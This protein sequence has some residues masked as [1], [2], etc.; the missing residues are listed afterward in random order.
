M[1]LTSRKFILAE[2]GLARLVWMPKDLKEAM[3][4]QLSARAQ[5]MGLNG[6][7]DKIADE[8]IAIDS[9]TLMA[10]LEK[11]GHPALTMDALF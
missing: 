11:V 5:E 4:A 2:G 7:V 3:R 10:H 9:E 6:F 8:T 1:Y